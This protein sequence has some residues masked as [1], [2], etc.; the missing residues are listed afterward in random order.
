MSLINKR[1]IPFALAVLALLPVGAQA[2]GRSD[3]TVTAQAD[4]SVVEMATQLRLQVRL[5]GPEGAYLVN[6]PKADT[7]IAG[8]DVVKVEADTVKE[9]GKTTV[10]YDVTIQ[11][12]DPGLVTIPP[13]AALT[14]G[15]SGDTVFSDIVTLK[16]LPVDVDSLETI[17]PM[18][19][20]ATPD[21]RWYDYV[22]N[23]LLYVLLGLFVAAV[24][25]AA[26]IFY[27][28]RS[29]IVA[30]ERAKPVPPYELAME[31]LNTLREQ[32]LGESG[33]DRQF[34]TELVDILRQYLE[35]RFGINAMEMTSTQIVRALRENTETRMSADEIKNVL[36]I[37]DFVKFARQRPLADDNARSLRRAFEFVE[38]TRPQPETQE[39]PA[40][41][42]TP[43]IVN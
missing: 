18:A 27:R 3:V 17:N 11:P 21:T 16:V 9:S 20:T 10:T 31:R 19:A 5:V 15:N 14:A 2:A 25:V 41:G 38:S 1:I 13:F 22:P 35:G 6:P 43:T 39:T 36:A 8:V 26:W 42:T 33:Q 12:F 34:Y 30:I 28:R 4:S 23:W 29:R 32:R 7:P 24:A 40:D 37:A